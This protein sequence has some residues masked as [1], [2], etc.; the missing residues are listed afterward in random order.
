MQNRPH[1]NA[2]VQHDLDEDGPKAF[3]FWLVQEVGVP[4]LL[5]LLKAYHVSEAA[6]QGLAYNVKPAV[7]KR[8]PRERK[9]DPPLPKQQQQQPPLRETWRAKEKRLAK[10]LYEGLP[11]AGKDGGASRVN[12]LLRRVQRLRN[13]DWGV[14]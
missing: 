11:P 3:E 7:P 13:S 9:A 6:R 10:A 14:L 1:F 8:P 2:G 12:E 5:K 4:A